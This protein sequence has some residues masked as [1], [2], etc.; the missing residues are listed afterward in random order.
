MRRVHSYEYSFY[1]GRRGRQ[2]AEDR[3]EREQ[4]TWDAVCILFDILEEERIE[5]ELFSTEGLLEEQGK[6]CRG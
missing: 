4:Q 5:D 2:R 6:V 1:A 3:G